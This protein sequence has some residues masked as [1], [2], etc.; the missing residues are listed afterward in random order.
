M[1]AAGIKTVMNERGGK[2]TVEEKVQ[3][4][5][6]GVAFCPPQVTLCHE[7]LVTR[8]VEKGGGTERRMEAFGEGWRSGLARGLG[9]GSCKQRG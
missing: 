9:H 3:D 1:A 8:T 6:N 2:C 4:Y 5:T 7:D